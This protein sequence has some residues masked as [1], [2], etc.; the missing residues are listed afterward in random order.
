M[1][2]I[3][4]E[5]TWS[6]VSTAAKG[7]V[8]DPCFVSAIEA[9]PQYSRGYLGLA[10]YEFRTLKWGEPSDRDA[11][12]ACAFDAALTAT[13]LDANDAECHWALG[14]VYLWK[15]D[16]GKALASY[17]RARTLCPNHADLLSDYCDA[18]TYLGRFEEAIAVGKTALRLN[19]N[20][21]DWYLWNVAAGYYLSRNY[22]EALSYL[23]RMAQPG[24]AYRLIA[25]TYGQLGL[26]EEARRAAAELLKVNP[27][28]SISR[29]AAQAP[30]TNPDDLAHYVIGL[31]LADLPE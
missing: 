12:L 28:F 4:E 6:E 29:F 1:T 8:R 30:Y 23:Q 27:E 9:D 18:L 3:S 14:L 10:R 22:I 31:R 16:P 19:P 17:E 24:P 26:R 21:P 2:T 7:L 5:N 13:T 15:K 20:Q 11:T 25:A